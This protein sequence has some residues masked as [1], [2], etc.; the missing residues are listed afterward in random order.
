LS[1]RRPRQAIPTQI[2][3]APITENSTTNVTWTS[4]APF[5][6][7]VC[8]YDVIATGLVPQSAGYSTQVDDT[9][10]T[11]FGS[12]YAVGSVAN[13]FSSPDTFT[14]ECSGV[15]GNTVGSFELAAAFPG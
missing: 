8:E 12:L 10:N 2:A 4:S 15:G 3:T 5:L 6:I 13:G 1:D 9:T 11:H 14:L 7:S